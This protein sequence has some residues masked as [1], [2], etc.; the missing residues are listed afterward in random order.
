M[1]RAVGKERIASRVALGGEGDM[2]GLLRLRLRLR[3][4][5]GRGPAVEG[6]RRGRISLRRSLLEWRL[7]R[8]AFHGSKA[9]GGSSGTGN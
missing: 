2:E 6:L 4:G 1:L 9:G 8:M 3:G 5:R 7:R